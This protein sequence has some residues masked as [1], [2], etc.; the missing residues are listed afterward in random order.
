MR[1]LRFVGWLTE[2]S[3]RR[4]RS[5]LVLGA[6]LGLA[7]AWLGSRLE[8]RTSFEELLPED[9]PSVRSARELARRVGGDGTVLVLVEAEGGPQE[10]PGAE[11]LAPRLAAAFAA[12]GPDVVRSVE[13]NQD[14][15]KRWYADHWPLFLP[16]EDLRGARDALVKVL[17]E[18]KARLNPTLTLL[19]EGAPAADGEAGA[20]ELG[21][22]P[23]LQRLLDP[24]RPS[25]R[26]EVEQRFAR[27]A[28]GFLVHP[29]RRSLTLVV[30]T[31]GTSL[32]ISEVRV[33]LARMQQAV[34]ALRPELE[35]RHLRVSFGGSY[36]ILL[37]EYGALVRDAA[38]SFAAV[39]AILLL[40]MTFFFGEL[41]L[42]LA[43]GATLL[44][45]VAVTFGV[46]W[47][48]IGYL[49]TQTAFLGTIVAGNGINYGII[50]LGRLK[51]L[52]RRG[53]PLARACHDAARVTASGTLLAAVGTSVAYGTLMIATN[54][55]FRHF[56]FIGGIGMVVCW[57]ATFALLPAL[58]VLL[59]RLR[60][61]RVR[62]R[63]PPPRRAVAALD[64]LLRHPRLVVG[65]FAVLTAAAAGV[66]VWRLPVALEQNLDNLR[67]DETGSAEVRRVQA[68]AQ[69]SLGRSIAGAVALLPSR[70]GA[71]AYCA[72][73]EERQR[74]QPRL[75]ALVEGCETLASVVPLRQA[76]KLELVRDL[77]AR[78]TD[79]VLERLPAAQAARARELRDDLRA[80]RAIS[81][82]DAPPALLDAFRERDGTVGRIAFVRARGEARLELVPNLRRFAAAVRGVP[83]GGA[84]YDAAGVDVVAADLLDDVERQGART[85]ALSYACVCA[86][87]FAFYRSLRQGALLVASF[88]SGAILMLGFTAAAGLRINFFNIAA[89]PITFGIAVD[90]CANVYARLRMRR[91]V[92]P[93]LVEVVPA[94][95]ICSWSTVV[96]YATL[97][98]SFSPALRSFGWYAM[99]GELA[100]LAAAVVLLPAIV[101]LLPARV[102]HAPEGEAADED[103]PLRAG[104][105]DRVGPPG[106][107]LTAS[108]PPSRACPPAR[109]ARR[110]RS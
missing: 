19:D 77:G 73:L 1:L 103:E 81:E 91:N 97:V 106:L 2:L 15:V 63:P 37:A 57:L 29:D 52:R 90:Y 23:D 41:R 100:T 93:A 42:V 53:V 51:Q 82:A 36:P 40:S 6:L 43:L 78:L 83:V 109:A 27:Y 80:Q 47:A 50:Y 10:L 71:D 72:A 59:D 18:Q 74:A 102:W 101:Q 110:R 85:T 17:G 56:G 34:E 58:L 21:R 95:V 26:A 16:A 46:A 65:A 30:R 104:G 92:V 20:L 5:L 86:L 22:A 8:L 45:A 64:R 87:V 66:Y 79:R 105:G 35:A 11:E 48:G 75:R 96:S 4:W 60:P 107:R 28:G 54:R 76:E 25:P 70:E 49:N 7:G 9:V 61:R 98:V 38:L 3:L 89:Y 32:A 12:L 14:P 13:W 31:A 69:G 33:A 88:T 24:A 68:R 94:M 67:N 44:P 62:P 39:L 108:A 55:G 84:R 99:I